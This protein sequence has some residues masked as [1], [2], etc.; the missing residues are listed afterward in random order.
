MKHLLV[1]WQFWKSKRNTSIGSKVVVND[2]YINFF[3]SLQSPASYLKTGTWRCFLRTWMNFSVVPPTSVF[4]CRQDSNCVASFVSLVFRRLQG[5][6][7]HEKSLR[8]VHVGISIFYKLNVR[9]ICA[10]EC[11]TK[12]DVCL[13]WEGKRRGKYTVLERASRGFIYLFPS[14]RQQWRKTDVLVQESGLT[15]WDV[16]S[17]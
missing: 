9:D 17:K 16:H 12:P 8:T 10:R 2:N 4:S 11:G 15:V 7:A 5:N 14:V 6:I 3:K 13:R 1:H